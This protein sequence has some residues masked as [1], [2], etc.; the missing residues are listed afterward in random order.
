MLAIL[1]HPNLNGDF[2]SDVCWT[3]SMY[4]ESISVVP[5]LYFFQRNKGKIEMLTAH[6][7]VALGVARVMDG[8]FWAY[9]Y[10]E[11][12]DTNAG[13]L[14]G[15]LA[16]FS[17]LVHVIVLGDFFYYYALAVKKGTG[18]M[19]LPSTNMDNV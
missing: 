5:Q 17:Q 11:L 1:V 18:T 2:L 16:M 12:K 9:S 15:Y 4:L 19:A 13:S 8:I 6:F 14:P 7:V 3:A 10:K